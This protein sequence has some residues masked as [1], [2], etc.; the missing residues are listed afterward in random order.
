MLKNADIP[1]VAQA[2]E[3]LL[4]RGAVVRVGDAL[5]RGAQIMEMQAKLETALRRDKQITMAGFRDLIGTTRKYA[6]PLLEWFDAAGVTLR[7]GDYRV[8]RIAPPGGD[9]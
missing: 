8:L 7:S 6:V 3:T 1:G 4:Q 2:F 5:Y 9:V